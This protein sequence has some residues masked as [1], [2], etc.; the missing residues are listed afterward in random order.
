MKTLGAG[1]DEEEHKSFMDIWRYTGFLMGI[2]ETILFR[3]SQE[4]LKL[5]DIGRMCEPEPGLESIAMAHALV[6]SAPGH[7]RRGQS[8]GTPPPGSLRVPHVARPHRRTDR[9]VAALSGTC[10]PFGAVRWFRLQTRVGP[11]AGQGDAGAIA[12]KAASTGSATCSRARPTTRTASTTDCPPM[13][14]ANVPENGSDRA[15]GC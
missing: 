2:P 12:R 6:N 8:E 14:M 15:L 10:P 13:S 1:Y 7:R 4:A 9:G 5:Y 11:D 3:D